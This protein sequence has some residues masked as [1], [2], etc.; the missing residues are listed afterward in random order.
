[1]GDLR[2]PFISTP[3]DGYARTL[4]PY[5]AFHRGGSCGT[6]GTGSAGEGA[7]VRRRRSGRSAA[8][9]SRRWVASR[10]LG[11]ERGDQVR[12]LLRMGRQ[13]EVAGVE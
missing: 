1:M 5:R 8:R 13:R 7:R 11:M 3:L 2:D 4:R 9:A 6:R 10:V 12:D